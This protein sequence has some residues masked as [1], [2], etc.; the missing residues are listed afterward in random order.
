M[1]FSPEEHLNS[2]QQLLAPLVNPIQKGATQ[3]ARQ[4]ANPAPNTFLGQAKTAG[5][6]AAQP[7]R[8]GLSTLSAPIVNPQV[9]KKFTDAM[10]NPASTFGTPLLK[11]VGVPSGLAVAA[12]A[13]GDVLATPGGAEKKI[14]EEADKSLL[15]V[16]NLSEEKLRFADRLGGLANPSTAVINPKLTPFE[17]YG[18]ISLIGNKDL[19]AG[20]KTHFADAYTPRFPT[21]ISTMKYSD[22]S[23]LE[24]DLQ[25]YYDKIGK[26]AKKL[27]HDDSN[28]IRNIENNPAVILRFLEQEGIKPSA[29]GQHY[30]AGQIPKTLQSKFQSYLD[31]IYKKYGVDEKLFAGHT[32]SG[33]RRYKP[34]NVQEASKLMSKQ[35]DEGFNYGLGSFRAK[36]TPT[37]KSPTA[38]KKAE[39][40]LV[41]K[42]DFDKIKD[43]H[44]AEMWNIKHS[45]EDY[46]KVYHSSNQ[47]MESDSQLDAIGNVLMG[48]K[49]AWK[50]FDQKFPN[51]PAT[52]KQRVIDFRDKLKEMPTEYFETKFKRPVKLSEFRLAVV[53]DTISQEAVNTLQK[54]GL[55][56]I[57]H[58]KGE[59]GKVMQN[60]LKRP[61][62]FAVAPIAA[63]AMSNTT[64]Q[65]KQ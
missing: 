26:D 56:V 22:F 13:V 4:V 45:L 16:H 57:K 32:S 25:P 7:I 11:K 30:F 2:L 60:L 23:Q 44:D 41:S 6:Q 58:A 55:E 8:Q 20:E 50:Y 64:N 27:Y 19:I 52:L 1:A 62:A 36:V 10:M 14:V 9:N 33:N 17:S 48:E 31:D 59:K 40:R 18:D 15:V 43:S 28:M 39:G 21:T 51:A 54:H 61:E 29:E 47:F 35:K 42:D 49:D 34:L 53:P 12:G 3:V 38:I 46:A 65:K 5:Q 24:K 37:S 63:G